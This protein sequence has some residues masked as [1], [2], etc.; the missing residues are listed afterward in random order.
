MNLDAIADARRHPH[1][2][3]QGNPM[4]E[5]NTRRAMYL[6]MAMM[7]IEIAGGWREIDRPQDI[8]AWSVDHPDA[9]SAA[10]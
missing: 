6:T 2:F 4:A 8:A 3:D 10:A 7:V 9:G 1:A 5:R